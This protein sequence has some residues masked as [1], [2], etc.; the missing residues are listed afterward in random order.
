VWWCY[1]SCDAL[2]NVVC[3][4]RLF[5]A[6]WLSFMYSTSLFYKLWRA[7]SL[8]CNASLSSWMDTFNLYP[9]FDWR[10]SVEYKMAY[11]VSAFSGPYNQRRQGPKNIFVVHKRKIIYRFSFFFFTSPLGLLCSKNIGSYL[12]SFILSVCFSWCYSLSKDL[13]FFR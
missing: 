12:C 6:S 4:V 13:F 3:G 1:H 5:F 2:I 11:F 10:Y 7:S 9:N 8:T